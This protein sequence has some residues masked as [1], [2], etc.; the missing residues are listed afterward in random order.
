LEYASLDL[1]LEK[2]GRGHHHVVAGFAGQK[3]G[4]QRIVGIEGV[5]ANLD[6]RLLG[7]VF[8]HGRSDVVG[9]II[10]I[11]DAL[12]LRLSGSGRDRR[13]GG[14]GQSEPDR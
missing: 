13:A 4:L 2:I 5:V 9:P 12:P 8:D 14:Y 3:L 7:E 6:S 10:D 11:D 1:P